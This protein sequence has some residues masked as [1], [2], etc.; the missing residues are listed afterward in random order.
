[1]TLDAVLRHVLSYD[2]ALVVATWVT[3]LAGAALAY[4]YQH[5]TSGPK[6]F[7]G[8]LAYLF[9]A[10]V[11]KHRSVRHDVFYGIIM[12]LIY[13]F[14]VAPFA[15]GSAVFGAATYAALTSAFGAHPLHEPSWW[16]RAAIVVGVLFIQDFVNFAAHWLEHRF[17]LLWELHK[18]HHAAE[19]L[20][21]ITNRRHQPLLVIF[22]MGLGALAAGI[23]LGGVSYALHLP[24]V[25]SILLGL[26]AWFLANLLSFYHLRHSHI[27][28][29]YG[30]LERYVVSPAQH[31]LHHSARPEHF[32]K[33]FGLIFS[34]WDRMFGT[35]AFAEKTPNFGVGLSAEER[36]D[37]DSV[38]KLYF[39]PLRRVAG[40][41]LRPAAGPDG[42]ALPAQA[43]EVGAGCEPPMQGSAV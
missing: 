1:M 17:P 25:E 12:K 9:P 8:Y 38:A 21:P 33:N 43:R 7:R 28:L 32:D 42:P 23:A 24:L 26:D 40:M 10:A 18:V 22:D 20:V 27:H 30:W 6:N 36:G 34:C 14:V 37:Y 31:Q 19:V 4:V 35:F 5:Q 16:L 15:A 29:S 39:T 13:P 11:V 41:I 2:S 3:A